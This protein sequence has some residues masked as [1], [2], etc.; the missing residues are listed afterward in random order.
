MQAS[1]RS[2]FRPS[3]LPVNLEMGWNVGVRQAESARAHPSRTRG[4][5]HARAE[6]ATE[7]A[8]RAPTGGTVASCPGESS[9]CALQFAI[10]CIEPLEL[11][12]PSVGRPDYSGRRGNDFVDVH[13]QVTFPKKIERIDRV[14]KS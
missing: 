9:T 11:T 5:A 4:G 7:M 8:A 10:L 14:L 1:S 12:Q 3:N 6:L 13:P 2:A